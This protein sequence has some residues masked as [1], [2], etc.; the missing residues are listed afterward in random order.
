M[1]SGLFGLVRN[2]VK[3]FLSRNFVGFVYKM[4][5]DYSIKYSV[6]NHKLHVKCAMGR[7][8]NRKTC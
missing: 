1:N 5:A 7:P 8:T 4:M 6:A 3:Y 2:V